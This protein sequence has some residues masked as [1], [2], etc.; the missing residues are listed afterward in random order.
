M[1]LLD[2]KKG[3]VFGVANERSVAW[4]AAKQLIDHGATCGFVHL[5]GEKMER[6][7]RRTLNS[8]GLEDAWLHPCDASSDADLDATFAAAGEKF[9]QFDFLVHSIAFADRDY[10]RIGNF[11]ETTREAWAQALDISAYTLLAMSRRVAPYMTEG[12]SIL[13]MTYHGSTKVVPGYNV[14]GVAKAALECTARYLA[15]QLG[16]RGIRVNCVSAGPL[17]TL[18][19]MAVGGIEDMFEWVET[20]APLKR[21][22]EAE[23]VGKTIVYLVSDLSSG[24]TGETLYVDAGFNIIG[25]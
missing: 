7:V 13:A 11:T 10:L 22:I 16:E 1:G 14:M 4:H 5:P 18:S 3:L 12:G 25:V 23:E 20:K 19:A 8:G 6:R 15:A 2:G 21:N 24:V 17:R 9:G